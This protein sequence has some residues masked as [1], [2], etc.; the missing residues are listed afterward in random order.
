VTPDGGDRARRRFF[1]RLAYAGGE[2]ATFRQEWAGFLGAHPCAPGCALSLSTK[3]FAD[4]KVLA[5]MLTSRSLGLRRLEDGAGLLPDASGH[6]VYK[7]RAD[8]I[9]LARRFFNKPA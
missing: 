9:D 6:P 4:P 8:Q 1:R 7:L 5:I 2:G 3:R